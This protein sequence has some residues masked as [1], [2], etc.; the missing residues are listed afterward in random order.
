MPSSVW[1]CLPLKP[2][3][4]I[5]VIGVWTG[6][7]IGGFSAERRPPTGPRSFETP[8]PYLDKNSSRYRISAAIADHIHCPYPVRTDFFGVHHALRTSIAQALGASQGI[9]YAT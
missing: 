2:L 8:R 7:I 9:P 1:L 3:F 5:R 4:H 6:W